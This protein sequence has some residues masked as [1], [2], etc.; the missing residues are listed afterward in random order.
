MYEK[1][2]TSTYIHQDQV[3][4][5]IQDVQ[6]IHQDRCGVRLKMCHTYIRI[7]VV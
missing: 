1:V 4:F 6:Y 5:E 7:G 2:C 3:W